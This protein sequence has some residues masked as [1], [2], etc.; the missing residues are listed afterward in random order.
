MKLR[1]IIIFLVD[2]KSKIIDWS[3]K[4]Y[5]YSMYTIGQLAISIRPSLSSFESALLRGFLFPPVQPGG[6]KPPLCNS[7][8]LV[9]SLSDRKAS[10]W[11]SESA[12]GI[13]TPLHPLRV[14]RRVYHPPIYNPARSACCDDRRHKNNNKSI[15]EGNGKG[16]TRGRTMKKRGKRGKE[17]GYTYLS[18]SLD[19]PFIPLQLSFPLISPRPSF[20]I[21]YRERYA[22]V[23][24]HESRSNGQ[25]SR[26]FVLWQHVSGRISL[27]PIRVSRGRIRV[28]ITCVPMVLHNFRSTDGNLQRSAVCFLLS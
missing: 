24:M 11:S 20:W 22:K 27:Y 4:W 28:H 26:E 7:P 8:F 1:N 2:S 23:C 16:S 25:E 10:L 21:L 3:R 13:H 5:I 17:G 15:R 6:S 18:L 19:F 14:G 9:A 12:T